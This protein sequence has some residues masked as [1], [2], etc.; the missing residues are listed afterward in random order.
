MKKIFESSASKSNNT[1]IKYHLYYYGYPNGDILKIQSIP[2]SEQENIV[3]KGVITY[4]VYAINEYMYDCKKDKV[5]KKGA[6]EIKVKPSE[7]DPGIN[8]NATPN[9]LLYDCDSIQIAE[10]VLKNIVENE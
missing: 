9:Y 3:S 7:I 8:L 4:K 10:L 1:G 5:Y 6:K 2:K